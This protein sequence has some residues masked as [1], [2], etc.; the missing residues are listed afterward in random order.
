MTDHEIIAAHQRIVFLVS[1]ATITGDDLSEIIHKLNAISDLALRA[2][3]LDTELHD[4]LM[5]HANK[6]LDY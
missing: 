2:A 5:R 6:R 4:V 1:S 3:S